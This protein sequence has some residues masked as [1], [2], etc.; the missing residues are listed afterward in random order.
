MEGE[1]E[2]WDGRGKVSGLGR[3]GDVEGY[4]AGKGGGKDGGM[5]RFTRGGVVRSWFGAGELRGV[6]GC[7]GG[8]SAA[9]VLPGC[10]FSMG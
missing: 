6:V 7:V 3:V 8:H 5:R 4:G 10:G 1:D 9:V 2:G